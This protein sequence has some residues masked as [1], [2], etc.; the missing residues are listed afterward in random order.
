MSRNYG[1]DWNRPLVIGA[2]AL[3]LGLGAASWAP[4]ARAAQEA[5][6]PE[7]WTLAAGL[8]AGYLNDDAEAC[9]GD[10]TSR[11]EV[12]A[13][14]S[15]LLRLTYAWT[16]AV[17]V[18]VD[19]QYDA[20]RWEVEN[21]LEERYSHFRSYTVAVGATYLFEPRDLGR[22]GTFRPLVKAALGYRLLDAELDAPVQDYDHGFGGEVAVGLRKG[23]FDGRVGYSYYRHDVGRRTPA[24]TDTEDLVLD[25]IFVELTYAFASW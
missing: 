15:P 21:A 2:V 7:R 14:L 25:D 9:A 1:R 10:C 4:T 6:K 22:L 19:A 11:L 24:A 13:R 3:A 23:R 18:E 12:D 8:A 17:L 20:Y 16:D 5:P